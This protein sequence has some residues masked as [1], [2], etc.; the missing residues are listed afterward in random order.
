MNEKNTFPTKA[1][2][3]LKIV[4]SMLAKDETI[5][6]QIRADRL[7]GMEESRGLYAKCHILT[8][9]FVNKSPLNYKFISDSVETR[10]NNATL[11][12][13]EMFMGRV[14]SDLIKAGVI[15]ATETDGS[16]L[17]DNSEI[18]FNADSGELIKKLVAVEKQMA[19]KRREIDQVTKS[20]GEYNWARKG[21]RMPITDNRL[22]GQILHQ[23]ACA[24]T[25]LQHNLKQLPRGF[26][27]ENSNKELE[28]KPWIAELSKEL[29]ATT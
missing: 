15:V 2:A 7:D 29:F 11:A 23:V 16:I 4:I 25:V 20:I 6:E 13:G 18:R 19:T 21:Y 22:F 14:M 10:F 26:T 9:L 5:E 24:E 3:E 27:V 8:L 1:A 28:V 12:F 17:L